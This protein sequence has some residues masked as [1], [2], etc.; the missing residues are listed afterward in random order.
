[1]LN[2]SEYD[3]NIEK[4]KLKVLK[5]NDKLLTF[6]WENKKKEIITDEEANQLYE[7]INDS[8]TLLKFFIKLNNYRTTGRYEAT[9]RSFNILVNIFNKA[10]DFLINNREVILEGLIIILS[11]TYFVMKDG[12]KIYIQKA[13]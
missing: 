8:E 4:E 1:M 6:D 9:E 5:L 13:Q 12:E 7:S 2:K 10:Q 3:L 11:Q